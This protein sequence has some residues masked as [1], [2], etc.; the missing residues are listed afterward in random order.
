VPVCVQRHSGCVVP[1]E[2]L[3]GEDVRTSGDCQRGAGMA[4]FVRNEVGYADV[5]GCRVELL[6]VFEVRQESAVAARENELI[7]VGVGQVVSCPPGVRVQRF[8]EEGRHR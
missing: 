2:S 4:E 7:R 3:D 1:Q 8:P 5:F 6:P